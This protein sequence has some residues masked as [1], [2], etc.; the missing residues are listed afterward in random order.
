MSAKIGKSKRKTIHSSLLFVDAKFQRG[1]IPAT[2]RKI[3]SDFIPEALGVFTVSDRGDGTY[4]VVD[5]QHRLFGL[6]ECVGDMMVNC[7]VYEGISVAEE[8]ELFI[9]LNTQRAPSAIDHFKA[10]RTAGRGECIEIDRIAER[11]GYV[12]NANKNDPG[13]IACVSE[14]LSIYRRKSGPEILG[15]TLEIIHKA[16]GKNPVALERGMVGGIAVLLAQH[17]ADIDRDSLCKKLSKELPAQIIADGR[18]RA[19][20]SVT[21]PSVAAGVAEVI[22]ELYNKGKRNGALLKAA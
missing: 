12:I 13:V 14:L 15:D 11:F 22:R 4:S 21:T 17:S 5:G 16:F 3:V 7:D 19:R 8:A 18:D 10:G 6:R 1:L 2:I 20:R 9:R